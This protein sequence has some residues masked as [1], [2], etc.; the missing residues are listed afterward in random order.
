MFT[1]RI[2]FNL[3]IHYVGKTQNYSLLA[4]VVYIQFAIAFKVLFILA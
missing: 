3:Q 4:Q 1:L 2:T